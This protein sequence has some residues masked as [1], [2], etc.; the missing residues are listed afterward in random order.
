MNMKTKWQSWRA[1]LGSLALPLVL[2][3]VLG[4]ADCLPGAET[5]KPTSVPPPTRLAN[6]GEW[7]AGAESHDVNYDN[8]PLSEVAKNLQ[9]GY[10]QEFDVLIPA[11][12]ME[13]TP[14]APEPPDYPSIPVRLRLKNV[15]A[16]ETF[17]AMN[18]LFEIKRRPVRRELTMN[19]NRPVAVLHPVEARALAAPPANPNQ[20]AQPNR[21][22]ARSVLYVGDLVDERAVDGHQRLI[23]PRPGDEAR[24]L[25]RL[26]HP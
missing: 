14:G 12:P 1:R 10:H 25:S 15:T 3:A 21:P 17:Q 20:P 7:K 26:P 18:M 11:H 6:L 19:G 4:G 8:L 22:I 23:F 16:G 13:P 5:V 24:F 9:E 2:V